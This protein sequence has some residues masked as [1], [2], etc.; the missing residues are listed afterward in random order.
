[1]FG[2]PVIALA[3]LDR[4]PRYSSTINIKRESYRLRKMLDAWLVKSNMA[5]KPG[6]G[7][8]SAS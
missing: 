5:V 3:I 4:L 2:D 7:K 1:V 8:K 6:S